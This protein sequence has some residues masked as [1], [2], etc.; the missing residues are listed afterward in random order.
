MADLSITA[1]NVK[2]TEGEITRYDCTAGATIT[3][4][5]ACYIDTA[6]S[7]V[8]KLAQAD[9][10]AIEA[11]VKGIALN[12]ASTGQPVSLATAGDLT[13]GAT[14]GVGTIYVAS[15]TAGGICLTTDINTGDYVSI[16]GVGTTTAKLKINILNSG[17]ELP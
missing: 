6:A 7:N 1:A 14:V 17:V 8:A 12:G 4:G 13:M 3:A 2:A 10:A 16:I 5:Q 15:K 11:T 9:N